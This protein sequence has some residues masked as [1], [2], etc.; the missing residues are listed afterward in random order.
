MLITIEKVTYKG[1][2]FGHTEEGKIIFTPFVLP[3][4]EVEIKIKED[5]KDYFIGEVKDIVKSSPY[6]IKPICDIFGYCG[7]CDFLNVDYDYEIVLKI[8]ILKELFFRNHLEYEFENEK[9]F[10][11]IK[12][13]SRFYYRNNAQLKVSEKGELGFFKEKTLRVIPFRNDICFFLTERIR[14][15]IKNLSDDILLFNK[16]FRIRDGID[17]FLK[18]LKGYKEDEK[19]IY[20]VKD[21]YYELDID[22]FF[23]VNKFTNP[24][25]IEKVLEIIGDDKINNFVELYC[26]VGFFSI[27]I[28]INKK[29]SNYY[30][31]EI[32]K[33]AIDYAKINNFKNNTFINFIQMDA[34][35]AIDH[36]EDIDILL[37]DP[38]RSGLTER[39]ISRIIEKKIK[40]LIYISCNPSTFVRDFSKLNRNGYNIDNLVFLD[41]FAGTYHFELISKIILG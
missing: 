2:G 34:E 19:A 1:Y 25:F 6:R 23:Q 14:E 7:G 41:N 37:V 26:G 11:I 17:I 20:K 9:K 8:E 21:Y 13:P 3:G 39:L 16:G 35:I 18:G 22:G 38:P 4:E 10:E 12:S 24:L 40:K 36:V 27:P 15:F 32:S 31:Y 5:K 29:I 33:K 28:F 30:A